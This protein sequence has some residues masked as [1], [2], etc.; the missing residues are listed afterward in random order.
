MQNT[1]KANIKTSTNGKIFIQPVKSFCLVFSQCDFDYRPRYC[2]VLYSIVVG[3]VLLFRGIVL[4]VLVLCCICYCQ[5]LCLVSV[6]LI[7]GCFL[8]SALY[9]GKELR[10]NV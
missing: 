6:I 3:I 5:V 1:L 9:K 4:L 7:A 8:L 2:M 10:V